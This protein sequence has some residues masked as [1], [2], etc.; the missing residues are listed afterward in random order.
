LGIG[1][2]LED[3][4]VVNGLGAAGA[5]VSSRLESSHA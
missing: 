4:D 2:G 5:I 3:V 1:V